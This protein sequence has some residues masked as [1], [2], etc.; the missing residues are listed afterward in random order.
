[1]INLLKNIQ[2]LF[3]LEEI[4][5]YH[6]NNISGSFFNEGQVP[7]IDI[8]QSKI[9]MYRNR[10]D[11]L[12]DKLSYYIEKNSKFVKVEFTDKDGFYLQ[13]TKKRGEIL[14]KSFQ[15]LGNTKFYIGQEGDKLSLKAKD[16]ELKFLKDRTKI[17]SELVNQISYKLR[18]LQN[19]LQQKTTEVYLKKLEYFYTTYREF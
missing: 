7:E 9:H 5:K 10:L 15:N 14:K 16:F 18:N 3:D 2:K 17:N 19:T 12:A 6:L 1:M 4:G 11:L 8:C 13:T